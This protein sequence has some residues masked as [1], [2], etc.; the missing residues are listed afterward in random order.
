ML[1]R[2]LMFYWGQQ[3]QSAHS[4]VQSFYTVSLGTTRSRQ[5]LRWFHMVRPSSGVHSCGAA[6][7]TE[8]GKPLL[9]CQQPPL[10]SFLQSGSLRTTATLLPSPWTL[11]GQ[12]R[13]T[14]STTGKKN[15]LCIHPHSLRTRSP[16][17]ETVCRL[18]S[19][20]TAVSFV[21]SRTAGYAQQSFARWMTTA[22]T[23]TTTTT[24]LDG[25]AG[26]R[27]YCILCLQFEFVTPRYV[28]LPA[29]TDSGRCAVTCFFLPMWATHTLCLKVNA[30]KRIH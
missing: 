13:T 16:G 29:K 24:P 26:R 21:S 14:A 10:I 18:A 11:E 3:D 19:L 4:R 30:C 8:A 7:R 15:K 9:W 23:T 6:A 27:L 1:R 22:I 17:L 2:N 25:Y 5:L 28:E 20:F 12:S